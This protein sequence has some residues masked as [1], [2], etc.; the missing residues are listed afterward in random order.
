MVPF[1]PLI[2]VAIVV[3]CIGLLSCMGVFSERQDQA[4]PFEE[5]FE[6]PFQEHFGPAAPAV[7]MGPLPPNVYTT[8]KQAYSNQDIAALIEKLRAELI[9]SQQRGV[10]CDSSA[11]RA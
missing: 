5:P 9:Q 11:N 10:F 6:E 8:P 1:L 3:L 7:P 4:E 2:T